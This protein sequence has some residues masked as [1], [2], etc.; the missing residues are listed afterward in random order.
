MLSKYVFLMSIFFN[1]YS[2]NNQSNQS[3]FIFTRATESKINF[4]AKDFNISDSLSTHVGIGVKVNDDFIIYNVD[5]EKTI[6]NS[7]LII[8]NLNSFVN[9]KGVLH[10]SVWEYKTNLNEYNLLLYELGKFKEIKI[11]FDYDF[12]LKDD[13]NFYCS[14][15][16]CY[17]L[18]KINN[19]KFNYTPF[20]KKLIDFYAVHLKTSLFFYIPVDFFQSFDVFHKVEEKFL[21]N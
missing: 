18:N 4:I 17:I 16:V 13:H 3:I 1:V 8:E 10:Y 7:S 2:Q 19:V 20:E 6:N 14:E 15:F 9:N 12:E 11:N 21:K 5:N